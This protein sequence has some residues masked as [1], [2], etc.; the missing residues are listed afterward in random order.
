MSR[1]NISTGSRWEPIVGYSRAVRVGDLVYVSGTT[2][3]DEAGD[4]VG[5]GDPYLQT[6]QAIA[7]VRT[8]LLKAGADLVDVVRTQLFVT[9]I[10]RW[11]EYARAHGE[12]FTDIRPAT[13][14]I[15]IKGLIDPAMMVEVEVEAIVGGSD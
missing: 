4:I 5:P 9:D 7:N 14:M 6:R 10:S 15:E 11:E 12:F 3:T 2:G 13:S 8:A 1:L